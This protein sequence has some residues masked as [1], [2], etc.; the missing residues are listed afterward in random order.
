[1]DYYILMDYDNLTIIQKRKGLLYNVE[2]ISSHLKFSNVNTR[3]I[4][5]R[6][7]GGWYEKDK[8][9][10]LAQDLLIEITSVFPQTIALADNTKVI[11]NVELANSLIIQPKILLYHTYR[12]RGVPSG[13]GC[14]H[15]IKVGCIKE[16]CPVKT[17]YEFIS[18]DK[19]SEC[20]HVKPD[21]VLFRS[22]QKL[23]DSMIASDI[24]FLS[25]NKAN[26][27]IVSSDDDFWPAILTA[28]TLGIEIIQFHTHGSG[29][30]IFY[31]K[32][33]K[34]NYFQNFL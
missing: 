26:I 13:L 9:T 8:I 24:I 23:V 29:T 5:V 14:E 6:L 34:S 1:M 2:C 12:K 4:I 27:S 11:V 28:I 20:K 15:P 10:K 21:K 17:V 22:E 33:V 32:T 30:N 18:Q 7:Y 16:A 3:N 19:C 25:Q 31:T